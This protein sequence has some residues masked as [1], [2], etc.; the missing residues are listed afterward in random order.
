MANQ[1]TKKRA[2]EQKETISFTM[3]LPVD[4]WRRIPVSGAKSSGKRG[5]G[6]AGYLRPLLTEAVERDLA[7]REQ[8]A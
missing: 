5:A 6:I 3:R 7:G 1:A 2:G 4:L 8:A